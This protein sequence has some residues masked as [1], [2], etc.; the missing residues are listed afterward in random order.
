VAQPPYDQGVP[1]EAPASAPP[2]DYQ[3]IEASPADFG[4]AL[5]Q[6]AQK[7]GEGAVTATRFYSQIAAQQAVNNWQDETN[8]V[9]YGD[10]A[11]QGD[12]GYYGLK[13]QAAMDARPAVL[14]RLQDAE[15]DGLQTLSTGE[16]Q[17]LFNNQVRS[18]RARHEAEIGQHYD[19]QSQT[20]GTEVNKTSSDMALRD[21]ETATLSGNQQALAAATDRLTR[22][23]VQQAQLSYGTNL[24][25]DVTQDILAG[26]KSDAVTTQV[27]AI[28]RTD[29]M[30]AQ[31]I[32]DQNKSGMQAGVYDSLKRET[33]GLADTTLVDTSIDALSRGLP[34][35]ASGTGGIAAAINAQEGGGTS[36]Q[37]A[38]EGLMP[39]T[40]Q[41][42]AQPGENFDNPSDRT[43]VKQRVINDLSSRFGG[44]PARVAVGFFSG[45][46]NVAPPGSQTPWVQ[47]RKDGNGTSTSAYVS[48][49]LAKLGGA[50]DQQLGTAR[51]AA[52][53]SRYTDAMGMVSRA[54]NETQ[55]MPPQVRKKIIDG[56]FDLVSKMNTLDNQAESQAD[57]HLADTQRDN[58]A[59]L[60][61]TAVGG[62]P[63]ADA[64]LAG[65]LRTQ[66]ITP[67]GYNA[68]KAVQ[69]RQTEGHDDPSTVMRLWEGIGRG[70]VS[71]DDV[72]NAVTAGQM[73]E[74]G[75]GVKGSTGNEMIKALSARQ[76]TQQ[77]AVEKGDYETLKTALGGH[78]LESG[79]IDIFGEGKRDQAQLWTQAQAEWNKRVVSGQE[80]PDDVLADMM[81]RYQKA[82]PT[83]PA[84]MPNPRFGAVNSTQD[85]AAVAQKTKGAFEAGKISQD[86]YNAEGD[87]LS[88]YLQF[89]QA[90][91]TQKA[92]A[93]KGGSQ[94]GRGATLAPAQSE[95]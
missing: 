48:G 33:D 76:K 94:R 73:S 6:G 81:P 8:K 5:A 75:I 86:T 16:S 22:S 14:E 72:F 95:Q 84:A 50:T 15:H 3:H 24:T 88:R 80:K 92:A 53:P 62:K 32:L 34:L 18:L 38:R 91:E 61:G 60:F 85:V 67:A 90:T 13:G 11:I 43:A 2:Q 25:P 45:P 1:F 82:T 4:G 83:R 70:A 39:G 78:A 27:R 55:N 79:A 66:Q 51:A 12:A 17:A 35:P 89:Y 21:I 57:K 30:R 68:I 46:G 19:Q 23:R 29:P 10:P 49:V 74:T 71:T 41:Q 87:L 9:L 59:V 58:E 7:L 64:D 42:Y 47:D 20:W 26:A 65:Y 93:T 44:D 77:T 40:F 63:V 28:A 52:I 56:T 69:L 37:G 54:F 36:G 31:Q